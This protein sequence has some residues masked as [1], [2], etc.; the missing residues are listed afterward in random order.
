MPY[1][2]C[3]GEDVPVSTKLRHLRAL[4]WKNIQDYVKKHNTNLTSRLL[5]RFRK[6]KSSE[7]PDTPR[8]AAKHS[9]S[10]SSH[11]D[12]SGEPV[13]PPPDFYPDMAMEEDP[14]EPPDPPRITTTRPRLVTVETCSSS[15]SVRE[16]EPELTVDDNDDMDPDHDPELDESLLTHV[17]LSPHEQL[18]GCLESKEKRQ[19]AYGQVLHV[20]EFRA[21]LPIV[22]EAGDIVQQPTALLLA[23]VRPVKLDK[24]CQKLGTPYYQD[25][26]FAPLDYPFSSPTTV[27]GLFGTRDAAMDDADAVDV[28]AAR[29]EGI[30]YVPS[31]ASMSTLSQLYAPEVHVRTVSSCHVLDSFFPSDCLHLTPDFT[32]G[33][34]PVRNPEGEAARALYSKNDPKAAVQHSNYNRIRLTSAGTKVS[35]MED[36]ARGVDVQFR[37][38][39]EAVACSAV[40]G[41]GD[42][43]GLKPDGASDISG[44]TLSAL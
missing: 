27:L 1:C 16:S 43:R 39:G 5:G 9:K 41:P 23:V 42:S 15:G 33:N 12:P 7:D 44:R 31:P 8:K 4:G 34:V 6:R 14:P 30:L 29:C 25:G 10:N 20:L 32:S 2:P 17:E 37:V 11:D 28:S 19:I 13:S 3:C 36:A 24:R 38:L 40:P 18:D 35:V 21:A 26:Q 22:K